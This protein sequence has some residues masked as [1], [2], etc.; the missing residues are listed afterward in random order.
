MQSTRFRKNLTVTTALVAA[1][2]LAMPATA[3]ACTATTATLSGTNGAQTLNCA[4]ST[5]TVNSGASIAVTA[6]SASGVTIT[7]GDYATNAGTITTTAAQTAGLGALQSIG[8]NDSAGVITGDITNQSG[9]KISAAATFT[10]PTGTGAANATAMGIY[11]N[12]GTDGGSIS[13]AGTITATAKTVTS[14][15][16]TVIPK[17]EATGMDFAGATISGTVTNSGTIDATAASAGGGLNNTAHGMLF[18]S[19]TITGAVTNSGTIKASASSVAGTDKAYGLDY[20]GATLTG[21]FNN[22]GTIEATA[23]GTGYGIYVN[24]AAGTITN[25]GTIKGSTAA[26]DVTAGSVTLDINGGAIDGSVFTA[27]TATTHLVV[28]GNF[29]TNGTNFQG[30]DLAISSGKTLTVAAGNTL[31]LANM[32]TAPVGNL[33]VGVNS[34]ASHG[35]ISVTSGGVNLAST[36]NFKVAIGSSA[37][38]LAAGN[39]MVASGATQAEINGVAS[40]VNVA[41]VSGSSYMWN[42]A[43]EDG[44]TST[45][46]TNSQLYL[47]VTNPHTLTSGATSS[48]SA[49]AN[50]IQTNL[51]ASANTQI[52]AMVSALYAAPTQA[53]LNQQLEMFQPILNGG[54]MQSAFNVSDST[55]HQFYNRMASLD[56][57][58]GDTTGMAAGDITHGVHMWMQG[59]GDWATQDARGGVS[60]YNS[61]TYGATMGVDSK[62]LIDN[63]LLGFAIS[64]GRTDVN[65][66]TVNTAS[67]NVD[68]YQLSLYG[69][70]NLDAKDFLRG[71]LAYGYNTNKTDREPTASVYAHGSYDANQFTANADLGRNFHYRSALVTPDVGLRWSHYSA[72]GYTETGAGGSDLTVGS[73][74]IDQLQGN[75]GI[76]A[77]WM[78]RQEDGS[79]LKPEVHAQYLYDF[80]GQNLSMTA[81]LAGGGTSWTATGP[82]PARSTFDIGTSVHLYQTNN[83]DF[84]ANYDF[85]YKTG[86]TENAAMLRAGYRF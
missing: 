62:Q 21:G 28:G 43:L 58:S 26:I 53:A 5:L 13:N 84:S 73:S 75:L 33:A 57:G 31:G 34:A 20:E 81:Q 78:Y 40:S 48:T 30:T 35:T 70:Y 51:L 37:A 76:K 7:A 79:V 64:Y 17:V 32:T 39:M 80:T 56:N 16:G 83:W 3:M 47:I 11:L 69:N 50:Q 86:Y 77:G 65:S 24:G 6:T 25:T 55:W 82:N 71:M 42:F 38:S 23:A 10:A 29:T 41:T 15:A 54:A 2:V 9:G 4:G 8:I 61:N 46:G 1:A 67:T 66:K 14:V 74:S 27:P 60:G 22:T 44:A 52:Q 18:G 19:G 12:G 63:G 36:G 85:R 45:L 68:S 72:G 59:F 49:V